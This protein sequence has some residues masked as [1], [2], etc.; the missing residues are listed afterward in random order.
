MR[1]I[2]AL[3][4]ALA[5]GQAIAAAIPSSLEAR[6][7]PAA[8]TCKSMACLLSLELEKIE[9]TNPMLANDNETQFSEGDVSDAFNTFKSLINQDSGTWRK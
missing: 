5:A 8:V 2:S 1:S 3:I 7:D 9:N 4:L 6:A